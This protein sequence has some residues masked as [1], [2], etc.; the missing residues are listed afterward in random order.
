MGSNG[1]YQSLLS[2]RNG[3]RPSQLSPLPLHGFAE[4]EDDKLDLRQILAIARRRALVIA[5]VAIT[6]TSAIVTKVLQQTPNYEGKFQLLVGSVS[7]ENQL[8]QISESLNQRVG[9]KATI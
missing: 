6:V 4:T 2:N 9:V 7:G 5:G 8:E 1:E 3:Q